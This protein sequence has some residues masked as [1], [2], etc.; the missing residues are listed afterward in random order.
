MSACGDG[1]II[2]SSLIVDDVEISNG[3]RTTQ[4]LRLGQ[5]GLGFQVGPAGGG[6]DCSIQWRDLG[7]ETQE[8]C[9]VSPAADPAPWYDPAIRASGEFLGLLIPDMR[10]WFDGL[11]QRNVTGRLSGLG[12]ASLGPMHQEPR[13]LEAAATICARTQAGAEYGRRWLQ[14]ILSVLCDP[15]RLSIGELR[16]SCPPCDGSDDEEG[17]WFVYELGLTA[18]AK[19][20]VTPPAGGGPIGCQ[21]II[22]ISLTL[23]A[24]NPFLYKSRVVC[25]EDSLNPENC[26]DDCLEFCHWFQDAP[27]PVQCTVDPP[28]IGELAAVITVTAGDGLSDLTVEILTECD[29]PSAAAAPL[30]VLNVPELPAGSTLVIDSALETVTYTGADGVTIDGIGFIALPF[31]QG[32]PWLSVGPCNEGRCISAQ[33]ARICS[34]DCTARIEIATQLREA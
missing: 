29:S 17:Q 14:N 8:E 31:G 28:S 12:G 7:C 27:P 16:S 23:T 22:P 10:P 34:S 32:M 25:V 33:L 26:G 13:P 9:F 30:G 1:Q 24:G 21:Q 18:G 6:C 11:A 15:C 2:H 19:I 3:A 5:G 20:A 4:Y